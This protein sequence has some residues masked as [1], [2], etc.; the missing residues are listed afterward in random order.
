MFHH[1]EKRPHPEAVVLDI[2]G[3][4]GALILYTR[5][6]LVHTEIEVSPR[7]DSSHRTHTEVL[8]RRLHN[9]PVYAAVYAALPAGDYRIWAPDPT[10]PASVTIVGGEVA[11]MDWR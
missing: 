4:V 7:G 8:E 10:L 11:E 1:H 6:E 3:D 9:S 2:G 5:P